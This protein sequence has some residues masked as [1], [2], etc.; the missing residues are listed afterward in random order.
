MEE[1]RWHTGEGTRIL[2]INEE[3]TIDGIRSIRRHDEITRSFFTVKNDHESEFI[4]D[5]GNYIE[6]QI[7]HYG[8]NWGGAF[9]SYDRE[10]E[11]RNLEIRF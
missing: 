7:C 1:C 11:P 6:C 5:F 10:T 4:D 9:H 3:L 8:T 2:M